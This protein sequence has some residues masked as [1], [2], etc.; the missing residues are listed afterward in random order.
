MSRRIRI[1]PLTLESLPPKVALVQPDT[2]A[3]PYVRAVQALVGLLTPDT[4]ALAGGLVVPISVG[5]FY[6]RHTD[7]DIVMSLAR[8]DDV[9]NAFRR[10]GYRLYTNWTVS[11]HS[12]G[13]L[14][15]CRVRSADAVVRLRP[16]RLYVKRTAP[17]RGGPLLEK[18]DLYPYR[19]QDGYLETCNTR[20]KLT[21]RTMQ[22]SSLRPFG[23]PGQVTCL[24]IENVASLKS[25]RTGAKH[26]LDCA[27]IRD[28]PDAAR[29][30]FRNGVI[31][32]P[33]IVE[34]AFRNGA[35]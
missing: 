2:D 31:T 28:G 20:R 26:R 9:V 22:Q 14:L 27:V 8:F 29:A 32:P 12:R 34:P 13:V 7:I 10:N 30:W 15:E 4:W 21:R 18:I 33:R 16:R 25:F 5:G 6:R 11:H 23:S 35:A 1:G 3:G 19:E 17:P 24:H